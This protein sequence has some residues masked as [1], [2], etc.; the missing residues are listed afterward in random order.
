VL[1]VKKQVTVKAFQM[2]EDA[3]CTV[4]DG[5]ELV[6]SGVMRTVWPQLPP[7]I[8]DIGVFK[9]ELEDWPVICTDIDTDPKKV[10]VVEGQVRFTWSGTAELEEDTK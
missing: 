6:T 7:K 4:K 3:V 5:D 2:N 10:G 1:T 9:T 8:G